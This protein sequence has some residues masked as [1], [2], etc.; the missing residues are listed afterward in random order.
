MTV[1]FLSV[2]WIIIL[3]PSG[4]SPLPLLLIKSPCK[5][6]LFLFSFPTPDA[7]TLF[8]GAQGAREGFKALGW[9]SQICILE[10]AL[11]TVASGSDG[12][13]KWE[14]GCC[15]PEKGQGVWRGG[16]QR[17]R[18]WGVNAGR[19]LGAQGARM[20]R[21][22]SEDESW[23]RRAVRTV[24]E[25]MGIMNGFVWDLKIHSFHRVEHLLRAKCQV[26]V[27]GDLGLR[28]VKIRPAAHLRFAAAIPA[29][30]YCLAGGLEATATWGP[31]VSAQPP[32]RTDGR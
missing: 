19:R 14:G 17:S 24:L 8:W 20:T 26:S 25:W 15:S 1:I 23:R 22:P 12:T 9:S 3:L 21:A 16:G 28:G 5:S 27:T 4:S 2:L 13:E 30:K 10:S 6:F 18:T 7:W 11:C 31:G 32:R 29:A